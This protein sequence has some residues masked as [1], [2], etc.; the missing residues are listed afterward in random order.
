LENG[1]MR[2]LNTLVISS[3]LAIAVAV[4]VSAA[5]LEQQT[6]KMNNIL[7]TQIDEKVNASLQLRARA[8]SQATVQQVSGLASDETGNKPSV[9]SS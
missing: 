7:Q 4:P 9:T 2:T 5:E 3:L 1:I 8:Q 6:A